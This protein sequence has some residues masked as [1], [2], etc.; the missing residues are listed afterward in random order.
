MLST[1][2]DLR[3]WNVRRTVLSHPDPENH[4]FQ[5]IDWQFDGDDIVFVSRTAWDGAHRAHDANYMTFHRI[6]NYQN[7]VE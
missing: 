1:S 7:V 3:N 4:A 2:T 6:A 5:Y